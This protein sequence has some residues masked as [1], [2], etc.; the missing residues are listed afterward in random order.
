[1]VA[2][3]FRPFSRANGASSLRSREPISDDTMALVAPSI[4]AVAAHESRS[5]RYTQIPTSRVLA[6]LRSEGFHP[7]AVAQSGARDESKRNF[8]RHMIRLRREGQAIVG[9]SH[10][11]IIL[12]NSHDGTSAYHMHFGWFRLV[13]SNGMVVADGPSA[14]IKVRHSG[15]AQNVLSEVVS[16]AHQLV[17][18]VEEQAEQVDRFRATRLLPAEAKLF[19]DAAI[20]VRFE[21]RPAGLRTEQVLAARRYADNGDDLWSVTN[22][23]QENLVQGGLSWRDAGRGRRHS[24]RAVTGISQDTKL[25]QAI[26]TL[27]SKMA[28][29]KGAL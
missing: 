10:P 16:G 27:A 28:E 15:N 24:S 2:H 22:R 4:F 25:N 11:E 29:I 23:I 5:E 20:D 9:D 18:S 19:A 17:S 12:V 13:C 7:F 21:E 8:T 3:S 14:E 6:G 26:W 1:M